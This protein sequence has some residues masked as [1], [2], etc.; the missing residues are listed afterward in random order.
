M[1]TQPP[2]S[3]L[4]YLLTCLCRLVEQT[5]LVGDHIYAGLE[6]LSQGVGKGHIRNLRGSGTFIAFDCES[7]GKRD[8][9]L[10]KMR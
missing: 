4:K 9:F 3:V 6:A 7:P 1:R 5:A 2:V 8:A 10:V